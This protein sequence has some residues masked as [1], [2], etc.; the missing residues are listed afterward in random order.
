MLEDLV[1][2]WEQTHAAGVRTP[3]TRRTCSPLTHLSHAGRRRREESVWHAADPRA[4]PSDGR[5]DGVREARLKGSRCSRPQQEPLLRVSTTSSTS[6]EATTHPSC[7]STDP[8]TSCSRSWRPTSTGWRAPSPCRCGALA[9]LSSATSS[10]TSRHH[11]LISSLA[12][13]ACWRRMNL[14]RRPADSSPPTDAAAS[15]RSPRRCPRRAHSK[16]AGCDGICKRHSFVWPTR[17]FSSLG[18][19]SSREDGYGGRRPRG[20]MVRQTLEEALRALT[21]SLWCLQATPIA[22]C[23]ARRRSPRRRTR[24]E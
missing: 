1:V 3:L 17:R 13:G 9:S 4:E 7:I 20:S 18:G 14:A 10:A 6:H 23:R 5:F 19:R 15:P 2:F 12:F 22:S 8:T 21:D 16:I 24:S 11:G